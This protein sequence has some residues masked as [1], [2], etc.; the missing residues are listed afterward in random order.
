VLNNLGEVYVIKIEETVLEPETRQ[1]REDKKI[2]AK[3]LVQNLT[4]IKD[5]KG[6]KQIACGNDHFLALDGKG[7]VHAM[8]DDTFGQCGQGD[9]ESKRNRVAPFFEMRFGKPVKVNIDGFVETICAGYRHNLAVTRDG[10]V[11]GWGYN[12]QQ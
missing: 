4:H 1:V 9:G 12:S 6:I 3:V 5:L 11:H 10:N 8:G 7:Q 2:D